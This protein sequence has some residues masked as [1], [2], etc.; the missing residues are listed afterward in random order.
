MITRRTWA[1]LAATAI[2]IVI[3]LLY[4]RQRPLA[5]TGAPGKVGWDLGEF[6][7]SYHDEWMMVGQICAAASGVSLLADFLVNRLMRK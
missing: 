3:S 6:G 5:S 7:P 1:L 4:W 2:A